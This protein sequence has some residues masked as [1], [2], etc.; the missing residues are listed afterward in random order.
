MWLRKSTAPSFKYCFLHCTYSSVAAG[1]VKQC[2]MMF[3]SSVLA[4]HGSASVV[5]FIWVLFPRLFV[6][7]AVIC[8]PHLSGR[9]KRVQVRS[10]SALP[11]NRVEISF[12]WVKQLLPLRCDCISNT[13]FTWCGDAKSKTSMKNWRV[14]RSPCPPR[15]FLSYYNT[16]VTFLSCSLA[17]CVTSPQPSSYSLTVPAPLS[18]AQCSPAR[19]PRD[20]AFS[21]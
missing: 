3:L 14:S 19:T 15:S 13:F 21:F 1:E 18:V 7:E 10:F 8:P 17:A 5:V 16:K 4:N 9:N 2:L 12:Y 6:N 11:G 20:T